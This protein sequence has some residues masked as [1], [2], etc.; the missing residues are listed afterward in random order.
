MNVAP[1]ILRFCLRVGDAGEPVEEQ[2]ARR[3]RTTSGSCSRCGSALRPAPL[4]RCR[5]SAVVDEDARQPIADRWCT[6]SAAT[7]ESTPPLQ[8]ADHPARRPTCARIRAVASSTNDAIVQSPVQPQTPKA[9]LRRI[10]RPLLGVHDL[11]VEQQR[12]E[13]RAPVAPSRRPARSRWSRRPRSP[14]ARPRRSRR[15]WPRRE[16]GRRGRRT[17]RPR[18]RRPSHRRGRT[19][20]APTR[21]RAPPST[22]G[23]QLHA[24]ADAEHRHAQRR[25]APE[26]H[27]GAPASDTLFGPP[28][29]MMPAGCRRQRSRRPACRTA[30]SRE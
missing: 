11:G 5:S 15:G 12:V 1:M 20:A 23:H 30:R 13:P 29:R 10:S 8:A 25:T 17:A 2:R 28:D 6:S 4:R 7:V 3:R 24:V 9:K 27:C 21:R 16:V 26:S 18:R 19:R 14:A 22:C